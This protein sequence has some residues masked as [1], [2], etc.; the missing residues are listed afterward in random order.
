MSRA[1][2][3]MQMLGCGKHKI[4]KVYRRSLLY[5]FFSSWFICVNLT[6]ERVL[7]LFTSKMGLTLTFGSI[8]KTKVVLT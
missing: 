2:K 4:N 5:Q 6:F 8:N 1:K 3:I 7:F